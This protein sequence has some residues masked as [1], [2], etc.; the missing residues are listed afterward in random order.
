MAVDPIVGENLVLL[1]GIVFL[2]AGIGRP[3]V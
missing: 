3:I 2:I 1:D